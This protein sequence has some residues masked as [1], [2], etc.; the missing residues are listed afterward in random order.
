MDQIDEAYEI[1]HLSAQDDTSVKTNP[2]RSENVVTWHMEA[3]RSRMTDHE[4]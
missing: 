1:P 2:G 4:E 3:S